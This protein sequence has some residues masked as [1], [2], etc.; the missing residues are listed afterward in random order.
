MAVCESE[1]VYSFIIY[2]DIS[3]DTREVYPYLMKRL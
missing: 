1:S 2:D 3:N